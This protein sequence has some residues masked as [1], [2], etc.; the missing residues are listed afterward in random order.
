LPPGVL[1]ALSTTMIGAG[2]NRPLC[3][4]RTANRG[5]GQEKSSADH[6]PSAVSDRAGTTKPALIALR[7]FQILVAKTPVCVVRELSGTNE[8]DNARQVVG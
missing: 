8:I 6:I 1:L 3:L 2:R 7:Q 5:R 4:Y